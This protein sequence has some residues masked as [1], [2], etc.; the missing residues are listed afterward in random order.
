MLTTSFLLTAHQRTS[1]KP[2]RAVEILAKSKPFLNIKAFLHLDYAI[3]H[4]HIQYG[5]T[6]W[7]S[8]YKTYLNKLS[9]LQNI[10]VKIIEGGSC[11]D[12]A[13]SFYSKLGIL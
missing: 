9:T 10:V 8:T 3:F 2:S 5:I 7:S 1:K 13:T 11:S 4:S 6:S 12:R